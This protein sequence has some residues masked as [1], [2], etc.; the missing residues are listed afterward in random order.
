MTL[1][2]SA[3]NRRATPLPPPFETDPESALSGLRDWAL[4][5]RQL[6]RSLPE[7]ELARHAFV[8]ALFYEGI[9]HVVAVKDAGL[10][11]EEIQVE[12]DEAKAILQ[13][14]PFIQRLQT[15]PRGYAG[16]FETIEY[17]CRAENHAEPESIGWYLEALVLGS[18]ISQQHRN[19]LARQ[20]SLMAD[21][22]NRKPDARILIVACGSAADVRQVLPALEASRCRLV[23]ND[24][25][26]EALAFCRAEL[27]SLEGRV[28]YVPGNPLRR[29]RDLA[30]HGP[31]DLV[32]CGGLF[33]YLT[34][35]QSTFFLERLVRALVRGEADDASDASGGR[36]FF[37]NVGEGN[38]FRPWMEH[39]GDWRL[40][41]RS[42][43]ELH[44]MLLGAGVPPSRVQI[45]PDL[46]RLTWLVEA[47][48]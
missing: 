21:L 15:W 14:S 35:R 8:T 12:I 45:R 27:A 11:D 20:A 9:A 26:A 17:L 1:A 2:S 44:A 6:A 5:F 16:D 46:T 28:A 22:V 24:V 43:R 42:P 7:S 19:K 40:I 29:I 3:A 32:L 33:D 30:A 13:S 31:F 4:R 41:E 18:P 48:G 25:D 10:T 39:F 36:L 34:E 38:P 37:T 23:L 47:R